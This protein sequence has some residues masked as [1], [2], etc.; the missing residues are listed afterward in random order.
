MRQEN[1]L[2]ISPITVLD[3]DHELWETHIGN[4]EMDLL[5]SVWGKSEEESRE[6]AKILIFSVNSKNKSG[7]VLQK[8]LPL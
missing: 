5:F 3:N 2:R 1:E 6:R 8:T 4:S 7:N